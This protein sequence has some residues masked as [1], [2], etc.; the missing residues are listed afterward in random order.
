VGATYGEPFKYRHGPFGVTDLPGV[1]S[2]EKEF[3]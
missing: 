2:N 3:R 1:L